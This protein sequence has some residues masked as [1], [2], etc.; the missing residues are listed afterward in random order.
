[1]RDKGSRGFQRG[2]AKADLRNE[3]NLQVG[4]TTSRNTEFFE[5]YAYSFRSSGFGM[6]G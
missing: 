3:K 5:E 1:M 4:K 6:P 2:V